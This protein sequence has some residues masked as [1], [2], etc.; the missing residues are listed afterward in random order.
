MRGHTRI[1][2][3]SVRWGT[4][5]IRHCNRTAS[6]SPF[7][8]VLRQSGEVCLS[9]FPQDCI[10][11]YPA[12]FVHLH[13][14]CC[15]LFKHVVD[16]GSVAF[17]EGRVSY[18]YCVVRLL[19]LSFRCLSFHLPF[20]LCILGFCIIFLASLWFSWI[21]VQ[22]LLFHALP[23]NWTCTWWF[24]IWWFAAWC[25]WSGEWLCISALACLDW[26]G[27]PVCWVI[28]IA[29]NGVGGFGD[30]CWRVLS[31]DDYIFPILAWII[32]HSVQLLIF[33]GFINLW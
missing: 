22:Q 15:C 11:P 33:G 16:G 28:I 30:C 3:G 17:K 31:R 8:L 14:S 1:K 20:H 5:I 25:A 13:L 23:M 24:W 29:V 9:T 18:V 26:E 32:A 2:L 10:H 6:R 27:M 4:T 21:Q 7:Q 19:H 12:L